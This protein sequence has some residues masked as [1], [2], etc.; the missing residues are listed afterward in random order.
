MSLKQLISKI[1]S[2]NKLKKIF[3]LFVAFGFICSIVTGSFWDIFFHLD[4]G[5]LKLKYLLSLGKYQNFVHQHHT[6]KYYPGVYDTIT[7]FIISMFPKTLMLELANILTFAVGIFGLIGLKKFCKFL[8]GKNIA[9]IFFIITLLSPIYFGHMIMNPKDIIV[10]SCFFWILY[11][12]YKFFYFKKINKEEAAY[13]V[14]LL[15][16]F[17]TGSKIVFVGLL[18]P[19][20]IIIVL[21]IFLSKKKIKKKLIFINFKNLLI[22]FFSAYAL[23][24]LFWTHV[25][26]NIIY[27]PL[28][29]FIEAVFKN[30]LFG[31]P[32]SLYANKI[33]ETSNAP[34]DY[35]FTNL[36]FKLPVF[37][38][39]LLI[40]L[41]FRI[42][43][44]CLYFYNT[45]RNFKKKIIYILMIIFFPLF[46]SIIL[47][48]KIY[49]GLRNF[50][51]IIPL[52]NILAA[53]VIYYIF[54]NIKKKIVKFFSIICILNF[55]YCLFYFFSL[56]PY[57]YIYTN[58]LNRL[59][60][61]NYS[62]ENDYLGTSAKS[63]LKKFSKENLSNKNYTI[64][65][66]VNHELIKFYLNK[67]NLSNFKL[68]DNENFDYIIL[69][70]RPLNSKY[71]C[72]NYY[73]GKKYEEIVN[74][75]RNGII[76]SSIVKKKIN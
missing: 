52:I 42:K 7:Y 34:R 3:F 31:V 4:N 72:Q 48:L 16:G 25:H 44:I 39:L 35:L 51:F 36:F 14:G 70:N 17:G 41:I 26:S 12:L 61:N 30:D 67:Y 21:E 76:L 20:I 64:A 37:I 22:V 15:I 54:K 75:K 69:I 10:S 19:I 9:I 60:L 68:T 53:I 43:E 50:I 56:T 23:V 40:F 47:N 63:L 59:I 11:Y 55:I 71:T 57:Q 29:L 8:F 6:Y 13:K 38:I 58:Y 62:F 46:L 66:C 18:L 27:K 24:I 65:S 32:Y 49:D 74:I 2:T 33:I 28:E 5:Q 1:N 73:K 45:I